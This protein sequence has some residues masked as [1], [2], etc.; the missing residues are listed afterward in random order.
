MIVLL[1]PGYAH[2]RNTLFGLLA[3]AC[4]LL[5][6]YTS[7][8]NDY[9]GETLPGRFP[10]GHIH[11]ASGNLFVDTFLALQQHNPRIVVSSIS[12][13]VYTASAFLWARLRR[14]SIIL[15]IEEWVPPQR[16]GASALRYL[17]R[18]LR[19]K[20]GNIV[21]RNADAVVATG[22][23][24]AEFCRSVGVPEARLLQ[25]IQCS[26]D[27]ALTCGDMRDPIAPHPPRF[28]FVSR[29]IPSKCLD[30]LL[31]AFQQLRQRRAS[32]FLDI[33]GDGPCRAGWEALAR[34]LNLPDVTFFGA[35]DPQEIGKT[36]Q[37]AKALILPS[38][39]RENIGEPWGL[40]VNEALSMS[41]PVIVSRAVGAGRDLVQHGIN[42]L[43]VP[44][45]DATALAAA[46]EEMLDADTE[47]MGRQSRRI[48]DE[49]NNIEHMARTFSEAIR[50]QTRQPD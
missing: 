30:V 36:M 25:T 12:S 49:K 24:A 28:L 19:R 9:P 18:V 6:L 35:V 2:Y 42:G 27:L 37:R 34:D 16:E 11:P 20:L 48:F 50:R 23:A 10:H 15:W 45:D 32:V 7:R 4:D 47:E 39:V 14:R 38:S 33:G 46:M 8:N 5:V 1:Q 3:D 41:L 26:E 44:E 43:V 29:H 17:L 21:L 22:T 31:H 13:S 40:I